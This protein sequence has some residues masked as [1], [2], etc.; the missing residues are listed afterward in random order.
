[1]RKSPLVTLKKQA[2]FANVRKNGKSA[3]MPLFVVYSIRNNLGFNRLGLSV[4]K[5]VGNAVV[6]NRIRRLVREYCRLNLCTNGE[7]P[8]YTDF[9]VIA[10]AAAREATFL[11]VGKTLEKL[12]KRL[13]FT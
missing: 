12:F 1:V 3:A 8:D 7:K 6:R 5:K 4:S 9:L 13:G 2:E 11:A 10:R